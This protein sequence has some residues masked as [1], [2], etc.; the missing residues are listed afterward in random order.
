[1]TDEIDPDDYDFSLKVA[2]QTE[3]VG[4]ILVRSQ[5]IEEILREAYAHEKGLD[6]PRAVNERWTF[7]KLLNEFRALFPDE[8]VLLGWLDG[9]KEARDD[10]AHSTFLIGI[11]VSEVLRDYPDQEAVQRFN[12]KALCKD[13]E[14]VEMTLRKMLAFRAERYGHTP[15][16]MSAEPGRCLI[17]RLPV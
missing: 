8:E 15:F 11:Y 17:S 5:V 4:A 16:D 9:A 1:M 7:G 3:L 12:Q 2:S 13:A 14:G 10:A 6:G